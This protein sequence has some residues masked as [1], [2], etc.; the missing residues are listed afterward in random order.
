MKFEEES[1][2]KREVDSLSGIVAA[3]PRSG[4]E[5]E[6]AVHY[7]TITIFVHDLL[8]HIFCLNSLYLLLVDFKKV[9][10]V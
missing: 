8:Y 2:K 7:S 10:V 5:S 4:R 1:D 9:D 6:S 3:G